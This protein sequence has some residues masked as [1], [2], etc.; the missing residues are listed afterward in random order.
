MHDRR[1]GEEQGTTGGAKDKTGT[2]WK[3]L[4]EVREVHGQPHTNKEPDSLPSAH[5]ILHP[6]IES[7]FNTLYMNKTSKFCSVF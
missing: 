7:H 3:G 6:P 5:P 2:G 4:H 1:S